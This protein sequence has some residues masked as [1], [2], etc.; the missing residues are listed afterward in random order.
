VVGRGLFEGTIQP[1]TGETKKSN[2]K[3]VTAA[4]N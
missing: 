3:P 4:G 1:L 2:E